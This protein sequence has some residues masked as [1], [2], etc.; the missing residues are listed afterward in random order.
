LAWLLATSPEAAIRNGGEAVK[1]AARAVD[2]SHGRNASMLD[3][4]AAAYADVGRF[5]EA[6]ATVRRALELAPPQLVPAL[7]AR[8]ELYLRGNPFREK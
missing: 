2:L 3:A 1:L 4:L 7:K 5:P 6:V 8:L